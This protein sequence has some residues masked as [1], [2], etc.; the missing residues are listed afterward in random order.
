MENMDQPTNLHKEVSKPG[1]E[2]EIGD[3]GAECAFD[4]N[5]PLNENGVKELISFVKS[6]LASHEASTRKAEREEILEMIRVEGIIFGVR[7]GDAFKEISLDSLKSK[8][9]QRV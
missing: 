9:K 4:G 3:L 7:E 1:W 2:A 5:G 8:I 6:L